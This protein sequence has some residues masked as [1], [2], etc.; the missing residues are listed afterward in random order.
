[1]TKLYM[2][3]REPIEKVVRNQVGG[4]EAVVWAVTTSRINNLSNNELLLL[5]SNAL[6]PAE[7]GV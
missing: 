2:K 5:I 4:P 1:M 3:V 6:E 7:V